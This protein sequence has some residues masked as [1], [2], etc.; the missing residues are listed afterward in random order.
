MSEVT[1]ML[2]SM[3]EGDAKATEELL[4]LDGTVHVWD[5]RSEREFGVFRG[6]WERYARPQRHL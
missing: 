3:E 5:V 4:P 1:P 6:T 2:Q